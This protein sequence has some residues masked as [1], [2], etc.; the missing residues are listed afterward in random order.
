LEEAPIIQCHHAVDRKKDTEKQ[1]SK[2]AKAEKERQR[3]RDSR[4]E[5]RNEG[6]KQKSRAQQGKTPPATTLMNA[7]QEQQK[8]T[9][10]GP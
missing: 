8:M 7:E 4:T 6:R 1:R 5:N 9:V 2:K 10:P 3:E